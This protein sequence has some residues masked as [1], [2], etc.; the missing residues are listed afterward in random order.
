[1]DQLTVVRR[2]FGEPYQRPDGDTI[3]PVVRATGTRGVTPMGVFVVHDGKATW[4]PAVDANLKALLAGLAW[5]VPA[6]LV[7]IAMIRRPPWPD[8]RI[9]V[10]KGRLPW[11][12]DG[13]R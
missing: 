9:R 8:T 4:E 1:M 12:G 6:T 13:P 3:I 2:V 11:L 10:T 7:A 5:V